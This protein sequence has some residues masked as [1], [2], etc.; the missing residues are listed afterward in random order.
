MAIEYFLYAVAP[1]TAA[2]FVERVGAELRGRGLELQARL[3][4]EPLATHVREDYSLP[5]DVSLYVRLDKFDLARAADSLIDCLSRL[6]A[7]GLRD[8]VLLFNGET[9]AMRV[10]GGVVTFSSTFGVW[11]PERLA[12][13]GPPHRLDALR[14]P[15]LEPEPN[16]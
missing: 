2:G 6:V 15:A 12:R 10:A 8:A 4:T 9:V 16:G 13:F 5:A 1:G 7:L 3:L 11:T 14:S